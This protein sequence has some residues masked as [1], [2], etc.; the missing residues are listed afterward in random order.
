M[1]VLT[2]VDYLDRSREFMLAI[3]VAGVGNGVLTKF[4]KS[5]ECQIKDFGFDL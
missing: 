5:P 3:V 2:A 4:I 1:V